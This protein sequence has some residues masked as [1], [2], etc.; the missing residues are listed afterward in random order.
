V[1]EKDVR[2]ALEE[3]ISPD[4]EI[5]CVLSR[6]WTI[7]RILEWDIKEIPVRL[8]DVIED[9][10]G[11][12]RTLVLPSF[13]TA[14]AKERAFDLARSKPDTGVIPLCAFER[15]DY[16]R[17]LKPMNNFIAKGPRAE[18]VFSLPCTTA[19]GDD[20]VFGWLDEHD[21]RIVLLGIMEEDYGWL[22]IHRAEEIE[23]VDYRYFKRFSGE[24]YDDGKSL[25]PCEEVL[26]VGPRHL[27]FERDHTVAT[28]CLRSRNQEILPSNRSLPIRSGKA[29]TIVEASVSA[30]EED[31]FAFVRNREDVERWIEF[32]KDEEIASLDESARWEPESQFRGVS[33]K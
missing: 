14:F 9:V 29:G 28:N 22:V 25:G 31:M 10:V 1:S 24:L 15:P 27:N 6:I 23:Q 20:S 5:V 19:W 7:A 8:L 32:D 18:E 30:L 11:P 4:D 12:D 17:T 21:A 3:V 2:V 13:Y 33:Q 16:I 26:F